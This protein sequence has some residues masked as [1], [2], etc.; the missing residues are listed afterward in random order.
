L[1]AVLEGDWVAPDRLVP[2]QVIARDDPTAVP[3]LCFDQV[4]RVAMVEAVRSI[5]GNP[6]QRLSEIALNQA[7]THTG[8]VTVD[9]KR[10]RCRGKFLK[11]RLVFS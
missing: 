10:L 3:H 5:D 2:G 1:V 11:L 7:L 9:Q 4:C 6:S 8:C